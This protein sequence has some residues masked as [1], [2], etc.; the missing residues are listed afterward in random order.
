[1]LSY[2]FQVLQ[3]DSYKSLATEKFDN[4]GELCAAIL[5]K[6]MNSQIKRGLEQVYIGHTETTSALKGRIDISSS[7]KEC[8]S[9]KNQMVCTYDE[10]SV[11]SY[12]NQ[13]VKTTAM[14]LIKTGIS[15]AR[16][17]ELK[18]M[19]VY[20][21]EVDVIDPYHINWKVQYNRNN[22]TYQML[23]S[24]CYLVVKGLLQCTSDGNVK[25]MDFFDE[26]RM[27]RLYEKFILEY[28]RTEHKELL[29]GAPQI[30]W[31]LEDD[32]S[33]ELLP[34]MQSDVV[35]RRKDGKKVLILDA[36][37]YSH[38]T[39]MQY[40]KHSIHSGN[41]YQIF[42]YVKNMEAE[43]ESEE[44]VVSGMLLYARTVDEIQPNNA[45]H[46]SGNEI[47]VRTLDLNNDFSDIKKNLD[48]IANTYLGV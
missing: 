25:L 39:Q 20:L 4:A 6:G 17:K 2:A 40:D 19:L 1:M 13:I 36:K 34:K 45:Y 37:Y 26:Q 38:N 5:T 29:A 42:T 35:L 16:K 12:K 21:A 15:A 3:E 46:M 23:I 27:C 9:V 11:N 47:A 7:I 22:Q 30:P 31:A 10:F 32:D 43:K 48:Y 18:K 41:L 8:T 44:V 14:L 28:Y 33:R 24:I